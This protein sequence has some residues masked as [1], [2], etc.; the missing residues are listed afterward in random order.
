MGDLQ[1]AVLANYVTSTTDPIYCVKDTVPGEVFGA[2]GSYFS[3]NPKDFR[4]H[5]SAAIT[6][7]I[8]E[9]QGEVNDDA[10]KWLV[11]DTVRNPADALKA[12]LGK[13]QKFFEF[14]YGKYG[15]KSIANM[16]PVRG[17]ATEVSQLFAR[18]LAYDQLA[19]FIEQSSRFVEMDTAH[20]F[21][22][23]DVMA[24]RNAGFY[25]DALGTLAE[26]YHGLREIAGNHFRNE[27]PFEVWQAQQSDKVRAGSEEAQR[28]TY[29]NQINGKVFDVARLMLP[30]ATRTNIAF[31]VDARS[32]EQDISAWKGHPL[33]EMRDAATLL[34][35]NA[36]Q[37]VPSLLKYTDENAHYGKSLRSFDGEL[38]HAD[39]ADSFGKG[40][41]VISVE[42]GALDKSV[43]RILH[44]HNH[45][46]TFGHRLAQVQAMS[47]DEKIN[48]LRTVISG[49]QSYDEWVEMDEEFDLGK[50]TFEIR[51]DI[52]AIRDWRRHQKWDRSE[53]LYTLDNGFY[54][55]EIIGEMGPEAEQIFVEAM[56][57]AHD[58]EVAIAR[59]HPFQA[60]L[61][62]PM[63]T[64]HTITMSGGLDQLQYMLFTRST[65]HGHFSYREDAFNI[66]EEAL[67]ELPWLLGYENL[68]EDKSL[69]E[70]CKDAPLKGLL[71][72]RLGDTGFH[73]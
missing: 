73:A 17:V 70:L 11:D 31:I 38:P 68:P 60:Q 69:E 25:T 13:S 54:T 19:F 20:M 6:G 71:N 61:V 57:K 12:G 9:E 46:G 59:D 47:F 53:P 72:L 18:E 23:P 15:H 45:G 66:A 2:F 41:D 65:P 22:D 56:E 29:E 4:A 48:V 5:L 24:G 44:R 52:G 33:A 26:G 67:K 42:D 21:H 50:I 35:K 36:G 30:Q 58:S 55:P 62:L 28:R 16:V 40:V 14:W 49:R 64:N 39:L 10:L 63:A 43:A 37:V 3:R 27:T 7:Q 8:G 1:D 51:S 34:E 32:L